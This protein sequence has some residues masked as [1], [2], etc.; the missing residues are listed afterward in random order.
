M[1]SQPQNPEFR[2]NH[3]SFHPCS[4]YMYG[5]KLFSSTNQRLVGMDKFPGCWVIDGYK[6]ILLIL[7]RAGSF[8]LLKSKNVVNKV[9]P[10]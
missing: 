2:I 4:S 5:Q 7:L 10:D 8:I 3:E 1:E 6:V 9:D